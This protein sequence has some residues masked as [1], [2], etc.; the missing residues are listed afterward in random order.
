MNENHDII[1]DGYKKADHGDFSD[2]EKA[3]AYM[4]ASQGFIKLEDSKAANKIN[5]F[6]N[7]ESDQKDMKVFSAWREGIQV[8]LAEHE[9]VLLQKPVHAYTQ[10]EVTDEPDNGSSDVNKPNAEHDHSST[11]TEMPD[12]DSEDSDY[13]SKEQGRTFKTGPSHRMLKRLIRYNKRQAKTEDYKRKHWPKPSS[14]PR[15]EEEYR[16][17]ELVKVFGARKYK[18]VAIKVR[19][20][21]TYMPEEFVV[22][23][24]IIGDPLKD[25]PVLDP[26]PPDFT[27]GERYT[28]ERAAVV[29]KNH[30]EDFL[31]P[32]ERK[33]MHDFMKKQE[34]GFAWEPSEMGHFKKEF[35]PPVRF[36][37]LPHEPWVEKNIPI[38]PGTFEEV[39]NV[40]RKKIDAGVYEPSTSS[41]R[42]RWFCVIKKDGKSLR[43]VHSLEALNRVTIQHSG[44]PPATADVAR[45]FAG[46]AC[47]GTL[48][49]FVGYDE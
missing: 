38:P 32:D 5:Q 47:G 39:C 36:P 22:K 9:D 16:R 26:N 18:P 28:E 15:V 25:M 27:P 33:I 7:S 49:L 48:D 30:S 45:S 12:S 13:E 10:S 6:V 34:M 44:I 23:R 2:E 35:F 20:V 43:L 11:R 24:N 4:L 29:D 3:E 37:V 8:R 1:I 14:L 42:S 17:F 46:R 31:L 21:K 40:I 41:Y 19:P